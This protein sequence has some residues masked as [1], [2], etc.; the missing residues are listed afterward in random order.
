LDLVGESHE[1]VR[2]V[3]AAEAVEPHSVGAGHR[4]VENRIV[5]ALCL[6]VVLVLAKVLVL[7]GAVV[8]PA[9]WGSLA[10]FWQDALV[11]LL[12]GGLDAALRRPRLGWVLYGAF[13]IYIALGVPVAV[14]LG[15]PMTWAMLQAARGPLSDS[16]AYYVSAANLARIAAVMAAGAVL[17]LA[18][19]RAGARTSVPT[20][21]RWRVVVV[22]IAATVVVAGRLSATQ[23]ELRAWIATL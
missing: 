13:V 6:L 15:T 20:R 23:I 19:M 10:Y 16:I 4:E 22:G 2:V 18:L 11:A 12:A 17:P 8:P 9:G 1:R 7:A 3:D 21:A 14:V 5:R